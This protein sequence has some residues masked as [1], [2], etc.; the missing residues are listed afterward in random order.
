M[1]GSYNKLCSGTADGISELLAGLEPAKKVQGMA[2]VFPCAAH[3]LR[4]VRSDFF[5][6]WRPL[7]GSCK[8]ENVICIRISLE[9]K[10]L[11]LLQDYN[12][13]SYLAF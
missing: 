5:L 2:F 4:S 7:V 9:R 13:F 8:K 1:F 3:V 11:D 12:E 6:R 10:F